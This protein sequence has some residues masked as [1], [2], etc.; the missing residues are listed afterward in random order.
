MRSNSSQCVKTDQTF[1]TFSDLLRA[2]FLPRAC[3]RSVTHYSRAG[4][5][6]DEKPWL[7]SG[8]APFHK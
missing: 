7:R 8:D 6:T 1:A 4:M 2:G 5:Q 3:H